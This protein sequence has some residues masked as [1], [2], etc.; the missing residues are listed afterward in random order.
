VQKNIKFFTGQLSFD[1]FFLLVI[2]EYATPILQRI[3][4]AY[5]YITSRARSD[6]SVPIC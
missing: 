5:I 1:A 4:P 2:S 6:I 3:W